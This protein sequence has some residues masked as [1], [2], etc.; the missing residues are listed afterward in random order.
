[1]RLCAEEALRLACAA[2]FEAAALLPVQVLDYRPNAEAERQRMTGDPRALLPQAKSVLV[3]AAPFVWFSQWPENSAEVSAFYFAS[4]RTYRAMRGLADDLRAQGALVDDSQRIP[5][6]RFAALSGFGAQGRN[7]LL[8]TAAWGTC[9]TLHTLITDL[10]PQAEPITPPTVDEACGSCRRCVEACPGSALNG[11]GGLDPERCVRAWQ[12]SGRIMPEALRAAN[13]TRLLGC[14]IC[15]RVC[16]KNARLP[17]TP[18]E[19][20]PF[21]IERLLRFDKAAR[22]RIGACIGTNEARPARVLAQ[23]AIAAGNGGDRALRPLLVALCAHEN[24]IVSAHARWAVK[25]LD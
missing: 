13:G 7:S 12:F 25:K 17:Q 9:V 3:L 24:P 21:E 8:S 16:P 18:P 4:N 11:H 14:E 20:E 15:Q 1:M 6:K 22:A 23:A 2:G 19:A 5:A 10:D